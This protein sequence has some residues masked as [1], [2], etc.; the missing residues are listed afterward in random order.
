MRNFL[1]RN[2]RKIKY[3]K[4]L[5]LI[6]TL[7]MAVLVY[8][9]GRNYEPFENFLKSLNYLGTF[10][11]GFFYAY[12]FTA[13]PGTAVLLVLSETQNIFISAILGGV[14]ALLSDILI[15]MFIRSSFTDEITMIKKEKIIKKIT[16]AEKRL[17]GRIYK[18]IFPVF[19][20]FLIASPL[21]TEIGVSLMAGIKKLSVKKFIIVAYILHT[22]GIFFILFMGKNL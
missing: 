15:F 6:I 5:L 7:I 16:K 14:G 12:G 11:G 8:Y 9:E 20:G 4:L 10:I 17:F 13:A 3:P 1:R 18:Y 22:I 21:P 2:H 19:S